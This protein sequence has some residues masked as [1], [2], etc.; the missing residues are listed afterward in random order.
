[1]AGT[2]APRDLPPPAREPLRGELLRV[3]GGVGVLGRRRE[4]LCLEDSRRPPPD[5]EAREV[6]PD[7][8][9]GIE[10]CLVRNFVR[11][12]LLRADEAGLPCPVSGP[13]VVWRRNEHSA[14][15]Q[16]A[17][18]A[19]KR[20]GVITV[21]FGATGNAPPRVQET[22]GTGDEGARFVEDVASSTG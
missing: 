13:H 3:P 15:K 18:G 1:M 21:F 11:V 17:D 22:S 10:A 2:D 6:S 20:P 14:L 4:M 12:N 9:F 7:L 8:D 16:T 5:V 19:E